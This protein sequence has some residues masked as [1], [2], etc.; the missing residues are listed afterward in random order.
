MARPNPFPLPV[1]PQQYRAL[2]AAMDSSKRSV[3]GRFLHWCGIAGFEAVEAALKLS[4]DHDAD[5]RRASLEILKL[6]KD[7]Q[8]PDFLIAA[9]DSRDAWTRTCAAEVITALGEKRAVP[10]LLRMAQAGDTETVL[11]ALKTLTALGDARALPVC[12]VHLQQGSR[13]RGDQ[14]DPDRWQRR[15]AWQRDGRRDRDGEL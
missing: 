6:T 1:W 14:A 9:L 11:I 13:G 7:P 10:A 8:V 3:C 2:G 12:L 5:M 15:G 4:L